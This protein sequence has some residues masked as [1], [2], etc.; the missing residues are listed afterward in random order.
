MGQ[1]DL[2]FFAWMVFRRLP[3]IILMSAVGAV[4]GVAVALSL[5]PTYQAVAKILVE[6]PPHLI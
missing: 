3:F 5:K 4:I 6:S 2:H 1:I